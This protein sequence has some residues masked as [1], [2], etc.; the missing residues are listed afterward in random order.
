MAVCAQEL[1][2]MM[3][4]PDSNV[5]PPVPRTDTA[6]RGTR[7]LDT[8]EGTPSGCQ[9]PHLSDVPERLLKILAVVN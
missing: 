8:L 9:L 3:Y 6:L 4:R 5:T 7:S 1:S 2:K